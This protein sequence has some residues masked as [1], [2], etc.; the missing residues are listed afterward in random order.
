MTREERSYFYQALQSMFDEWAKE[1]SED[2]IAIATQ[3]L[4]SFA[5]RMMPTITGQQYLPQALFRE[6]LKDIEPTLMSTKENIDAINDELASHSTKISKNATDI[7]AINKKIETIESN[8]EEL[9]PLIYA[10][11]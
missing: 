11:L 10:G 4:K 6:F 2:D 8:I 1:H 7:T 5:E 3:R 9:E